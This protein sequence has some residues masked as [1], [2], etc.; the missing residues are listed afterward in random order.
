MEAEIR[1]SAYP[2]T[3]FGSIKGELTL[4]GREVVPADQI[5]TEPRFPVIVRLENNF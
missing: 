5:N 2:F 4:L 1:V 3:Q